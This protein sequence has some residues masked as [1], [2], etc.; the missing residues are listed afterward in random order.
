MGSLIP[1]EPLIYERVDDTVFA[2]Y[3]GRPDIPRWIVGGSAEKS[4]NN[5]TTWCAIVELAKNN[6]TVNDQLQKLLAVY[7]LCK[8]PE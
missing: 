5:Y 7:H 4:L 1:N 8:E 6:E 3:P 2:R